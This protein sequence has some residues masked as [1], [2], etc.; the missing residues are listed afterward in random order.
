MDPVYD[1]FKQ[2]LVKRAQGLVVGTAAHDDLG[3]VISAVQMTRML[4]AVDASVAAGATL[5]CGGARLTGAGYDGGNFVAPTV[6]E[7]AADNPISRQ[8]LFGPITVLY[9]ARDFADAIRIADDTPYGLT[10][11]IWTSSTDR[12][13]VFVEEM[14]VGM[15]AVNGPTYGSEPHMPFGG[16]RQSGNG[17]REAGTE[18]LDVYTDWKSV[19]VLHDP[20]RV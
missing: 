6:L 9:R 19:A 1:E 14:Q 8:E 7:A 16:F 15:V 10:A 2:R 4:A 20:A 5:L 12:A 17:A 13:A 3:P 11:A 18:V